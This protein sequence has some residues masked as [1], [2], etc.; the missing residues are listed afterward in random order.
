MGFAV[1]TQPQVARR[2]A[3]DSRICNFEDKRYKNAL[4]VAS[5]QLLVPGGNFSHK[6]LFCW[7]SFA[8]GRV[9]HSPGCCFISALHIPGS[10][11]AGSLSEHCFLPPAFSWQFRTGNVK[12]GNH[13]RPSLTRTTSSL[14]AVL[15]AIW[16]RLSVC[17]RR[18]F[19]A[20]SGI[21]QQR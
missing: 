16:L 1:E 20:K 8:S 9:Y 11:L 12:H 17:P 3:F 18:P 13:A 4:K 2:D 6:S 5:F 21:F 10:I 19:K 15:C 14:P 7:N